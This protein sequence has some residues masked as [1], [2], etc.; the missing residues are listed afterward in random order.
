[1]QEGHAFCGVGVKGGMLWSESLCQIPHPNS[2]G[3]NLA[4]NAM[5]LRRGTFARGL[6]HDGA[7]LVNEICAFMKEA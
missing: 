3:E 5:V 2:Y 1:M 7:A 4:P 6:G